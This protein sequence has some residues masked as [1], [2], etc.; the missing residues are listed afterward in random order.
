V[1]ALERISGAVGA[2]AD[3]VGDL[4]GRYL[5]PAL[6][7]QLATLGFRA[8]AWRGVLAAAYPDRRIPVFSVAAAYAAGVALNAFTPARGGEAL[9]VLLA[10]T[11]IPG[12]TVPTLAASLS[13]ILVLDA[14]LG[15][16]LVLLLWTLGI[17]P[18][19]PAAPGVGSLPLAGGVAAGVLVALLVLLRLRPG[20][21]RRLATR[22]RQGFTIL[23]TPGRYALTVVPFQLA[24]WC[25]RIGVVFL[26]LSAFH[27]DAG[28]ATAAL[29]VVLNGASTAVPVPG[30]AGTQQVL[31]TY[32]LQGVVSAATA[33]SFSL[34]MQV[35]VTMVNTTVGVLAL[36]LLFRTVRPLAAV[37]SARTIVGVR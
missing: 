34:S 23:R 37:R 4:D 19:L 14:L 21:V 13:V 17:L 28:L 16:A 9:K 26:V 5:A 3:R 6:A 11:R 20:L 24:A 8:L 31:A 29:V 33:I 12:S 25:C 22:A 10:R 1:S 15:G 18:A 30:G 36:M 32:A 2:A 35:G 27:I 7:L